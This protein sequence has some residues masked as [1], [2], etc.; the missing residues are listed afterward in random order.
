MFSLPRRTR[1]AALLLLFTL[2]WRL[3]GSPLSPREWAS[4]PS[5][6]QMAVRQLPVRA[7]RLLNNW[8]PP[9]TD[10]PSVSV[11]DPQHEKTL[12]LALDEYLLGVVAAEMPA[13]YHLEALKAQTV[14]ARTRL[15]A[16]PKASHPQASVCTDSGCCQG[17]LSPRARLERWGEDSEAYEKR[18]RQALREADGLILTYEGEP[19]QM[20]YHAVS[21]GRTEDA[22]QVFSQSL[23]YL[24]SVESP[25]EE[26]SAKYE[27]RS[28]WSC[29]EA[30]TLLNAAFPQAHA[31]AEMLGAQLAVRET[32]P[33][34][35]ALWVQVG[36]QLV[37][38]T[39]FRKALSLNSTWLSIHCTQSLL[40]VTQRGYGHGVG[41][42]QAGANA[43][44]AR[45]GAMADIL[46]HYYPGTQL[47]EIA[48]PGTT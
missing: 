1:W 10:T 35:R 40:T 47:H 46:S 18:I 45:G 32:S 7:R 21:G 26:G 15:A 39:D 19:I 36:D 13:S 31:E 41:M 48:S 42:S 27:T 17:Y 25:G 28:Q 12:S 37:S 8:L 2:I 38:G 14:A 6:G 23:P 43:M 3:M 16:P 44:A 4:L 9:E 33:S 29:Q 20:L 30:A 24:Q 11:Y 34:G 22:A 5:Q